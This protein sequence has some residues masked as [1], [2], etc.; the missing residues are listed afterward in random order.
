MYKLADEN[1]VLSAQEG[2]FEQGNLWRGAGTI[3]EL[4]LPLRTA[5]LT[6][7]VSTTGDTLA[8]VSASPQRGAAGR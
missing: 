1:W 8:P 7:S 2:E 3:S 4:P 5:L 6:P